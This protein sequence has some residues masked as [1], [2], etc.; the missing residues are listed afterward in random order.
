MWS[1]RRNH[2]IVTSWAVGGK[3]GAKGKK[4]GK[5]GGGGAKGAAGGGKHA[6]ATGGGGG[7]VT[8]MAGLNWEVLA[9][10]LPDWCPDLDWADGGDDKVEAVAHLLAQGALAA[11][12]EALQVRDTGCL[13]EDTE[14]SGELTSRYIIYRK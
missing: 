2:L 7:G 6:A 10:K 13:A 8:T 14:S 11:Y 1:V 3:K 4:G 5:G 9:A 12:E